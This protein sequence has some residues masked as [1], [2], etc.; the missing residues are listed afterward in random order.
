MISGGGGLGVGSGGPRYGGWVSVSDNMGGGA[1]T[2]GPGSGDILLSGPSVW[3]P[4]GSVS[5]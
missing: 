1:A 4:L 3:G 2:G 5:C